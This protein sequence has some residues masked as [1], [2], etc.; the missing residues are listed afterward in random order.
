MPHFS[1]K[2]WM[3]I[4]MQGKLI[5]IPMPDEKTIATKDKLDRLPKEALDRIEAF[6]KQNI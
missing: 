3:V 6:L 4:E 2:P 1:I 5:F